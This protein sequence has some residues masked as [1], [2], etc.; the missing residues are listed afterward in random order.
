MLTLSPFRKSEM[1][2]KDSIHMQHKLTTS[3][4]QREVRRGDKE[5]TYFPIKVNGQR[6]PS[7]YFDLAQINLTCVTNY[8]LTNVAISK[9][10]LLYH[11]GHHTWVLK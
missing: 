11:R 5:G 2:E 3:Q 4:H 7:A 8:S 1:H 6:F 9:V 10:G